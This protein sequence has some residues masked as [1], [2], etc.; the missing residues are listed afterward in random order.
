MAR[1]PYVS[2]SEHSDPRLAADFAEILAVRG[3]VSNVFRLVANSPTALRPF[4]TLS[5]YVRDESPVPPRLR[6][7]LILVTAA[8]LGSAYQ[9]REHRHLARLAGMSDDE[10][11]SALAGDWGQFSAEERAAM[12]FARVVT[13]HSDAT[14]GILERLR[15]WFEPAIVVELALIVGWYHLVG[16]IVEPLKIDLEADRR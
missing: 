13:T 15:T 4:F 9:V 11:E 12:E 6:E 5:R 10:I 14:D 8:A 2:P 7:L 3:E 1:V 16:A